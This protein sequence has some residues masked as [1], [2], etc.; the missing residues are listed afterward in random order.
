MI[1]ILGDSLTQLERSLGGRVIDED[2]GINRVSVVTL[3][4]PFQRTRTKNPVGIGIRAG[5]VCPL[6]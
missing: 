1:V 3:S 2:E 5:L 6:T 4:D